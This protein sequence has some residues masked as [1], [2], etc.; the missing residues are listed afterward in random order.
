MKKYKFNKPYIRIGD[1]VTFA[2]NV[3]IIVGDDQ[4]SPIE[5]KELL[6]YG[7]IES[8]PDRP[9]WRER[10]E[11]I[12]ENVLA[13]DTVPQGHPDRELSD[14]LFAEADAYLKILCYVEWAN[15]GKEWGRKYYTF[16][17]EGG[18]V[19]IMESIR[20]HKIPAFNA[21]HPIMLIEVIDAENMLTIPELVEALNVVFNIK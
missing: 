5:I 19:E 2:F 1:G 8:V 10:Y 7:Y 6:T 17:S 9:D 20:E 11:A 14:R 4:L 16:Y 18:K 13:S 15:E 21:T 3:G 12:K